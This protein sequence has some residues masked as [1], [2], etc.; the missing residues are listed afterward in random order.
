MRIELWKSYGVNVTI[1]A[2]KD[3]SSY[4]DCQFILETAAKLAPIDG[5]FNLAAVLKN[6]LWE[7]QTAHSFEE[8]FKPKAWT[9]KN[10]DVLTRKLCPE[11]RHFVVFS[12]VACGKGSA[13]QCNYGMSNSV[14]ERK[15]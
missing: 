3:A 10:L 8:S 7:N 15:G 5:I 4:Q 13:G 12:S 2:G 11:L 6:D 1:V 14:R 9:T